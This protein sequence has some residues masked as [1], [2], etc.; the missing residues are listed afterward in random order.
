MVDAVAATYAFENDVLLM[1]ALRRD[2]DGYR[3]AD[4]LFSEV[5]EDTLSTLFQLMMMPSRFLLTIA[6]SPNSTMEA[7]NALSRDCRCSSR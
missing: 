6:S 2:D 3:L 4:G 1:V 7:S 5:A